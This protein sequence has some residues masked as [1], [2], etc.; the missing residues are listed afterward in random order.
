MEKPKVIN[1]NKRNLISG[2]FLAVTMLMC[3]AS[4]ALPASDN[5]IYSEPIYTNV[6]FTADTADPVPAAKQNN[7]GALDF[8]TGGFETLS[9]WQYGRTVMVAYSDTVAAYKA[10]VL[11]CSNGQSAHQP[12]P[13]IPISKAI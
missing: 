7:D 4:F 10:T 13:K 12:L 8:G 1:M 5:G 11:A 6:V 3:G 2:I 9:K